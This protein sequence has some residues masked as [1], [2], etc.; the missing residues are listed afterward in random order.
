MDAWSLIGCADSIKAILNRWN[1]TVVFRFLI[2]QDGGKF[3]KSVGFSNRSWL[4]AANLDD[5]EPGWDSA[6]AYVFKEDFIFANNIMWFV[7]IN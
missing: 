1:C 6:A 5:S 3:R 7:L 4:F 2:R